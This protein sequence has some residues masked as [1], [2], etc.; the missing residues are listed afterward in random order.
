MLKY[1]DNSIDHNCVRHANSIYLSKFQV[2]MVT[3]IKVI[4]QTVF[5]HAKVMVI[6]VSSD[7][8]L[9]R[10]C[11][12]SIFLWDI[13]KQWIHRSDATERGVFLGSPLF[14]LHADLLKYE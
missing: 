10:T 3:H 5:S 6:V 1:V 4:M 9:T 7:I 8:S 2:N 14:C 13:G 11:T 12:T